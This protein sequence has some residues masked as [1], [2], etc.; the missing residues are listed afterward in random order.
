[1]I[2]YG[3]QSISEEDIEAVVSVLRSDFLTSGP[4]VEAF[5][6]AFAEMCGAKYAVSCCNG[7]AALQLAMLA[8]GVR[9]GERVVTTSITFLASANA[10]AYVGAVPDFCDIENE[11]YCLSPEALEEGW[12][13]D[14][15]AVVAVDFAGHPA[16]TQRISELARE[17]GAV[18]IEDACHSVGSKFT[19]DGETRRIGGNSWA[20]ITTFSFHPVKTLTTAE[21]G[22][23]VTDN[24]EYADRARKLRGHGITRDASEFSFFGKGNTYAVEEQVGQLYEM[25]ELG[26]NFRL[27]EMHCALGLSQLKRLD[28]F[29]QRRSEIFRAY[30]EAF[31]HIPHVVTPRFAGWL[32]ESVRQDISWHLYVL[33]ISFDN[34]S[35]TRDEFMGKLR[36]AG[37]STQLHYLPVH[38]QPYY[39]DAYGYSLGKCPNAERFALSA[40]SLPLYFEM[41]DDDV[42]EVVTAVR[43]VSDGW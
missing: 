15:K 42:R 11:S 19:V 2:P 32:D 14:T 43:D 40:V 41:S 1:M 13:E 37:I 16:N 8:A 25:N 7:T 20:D 34:L 12:R 29:V 18:V 26:Y 10:A 21:G 33:Q 39:Q 31:S 30:N 28:Q 9:K 22:M 36:S 5:E 23:L 17:R 3:K 38:L 4:T 27:S 6:E 24:R 35:L